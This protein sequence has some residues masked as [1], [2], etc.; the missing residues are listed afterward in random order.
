VE[1]GLQLDDEIE[2][3]PELVED[4]IRDFRSGT[5]TSTH[6]MVAVTVSAAVLEVGMLLWYEKIYASWGPFNVLLVALLVVALTAVWSVRSGWFQIRKER[7]SA[8]IFWIP[9]VGWLICMFIG[10]R[11]AEPLEYG[12]RSQLERSQAV[13]EEGGQ[14]SSPQ[15]SYVFWRTADMA[16]EVIADFDCDDEG[17]LVMILVAIV[18]VSVVASATIPHFWVV[19]TMLLLTLMGVITLR[20]LLVRERKF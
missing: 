10:T 14:V 18:V 13:V 20:E 4:D 17:C 16:G 3:F 2:E 7:L 8:R 19:A 11:F 6:L 5:Y 9:T 1:V 15:R 12:G